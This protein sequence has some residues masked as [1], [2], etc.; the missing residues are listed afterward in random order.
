MA[1]NRNVLQALADMCWGGVETNISAAERRAGPLSAAV[2]GEMEIGFG[3]P[4]EAELT[5]QERSGKNEI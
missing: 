5:R 4:T 1:R 2:A 3:S